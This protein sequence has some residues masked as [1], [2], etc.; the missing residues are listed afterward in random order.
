MTVPRPRRRRPRA[1]H[2]ASR[3]SSSR[4][5]TFLLK[6]LGFAA[7]ERVDD[8]LRARPGSTRTTTRSCSCST[9]ARA[10]RRARS[11]TRSATTA[12]SS[13]GLLDELE[14]HGLV[15]RRRDPDD[16]RR[17]LVSLTPAG[18]RALAPAAHAG[19]QTRGRV[20]RAAERA[21]ARR[22][23]RAPPPPRRKARTA[24]RL[25]RPGERVE[26]L[27]TGP[28]RR[29]RS[30]W[31]DCTTGLCLGRRRDHGGQLGLT[32]TWTKRQRPEQEHGSPESAGRPR[33]CTASC[34]LPSRKPTQ[35]T[36]KACER[37]V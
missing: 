13:S 36:P 35:R 5:R 8:G 3:R 11:P 26:S 34:A 10:R 29:P 30:R 24:L 19:A 1:P 2:P 4:R 22:P 18:T 33:D 31:R 16:R 20:P 17:H 21:G 28:N 9:R 15:E 25:Q 14:E 6:R 37:L 23:A 27:T 12:A 7:K 32:G